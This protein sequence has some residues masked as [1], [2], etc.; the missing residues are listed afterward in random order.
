MASYRYMGTLGRARQ[1]VALV[2]QRE[3]R[4]PAVVGD[5]RSVRCLGHQTALDALVAPAVADCQR[6]IARYLVTLPSHE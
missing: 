4:L 5:G 2:L 1:P 6:L 3:G